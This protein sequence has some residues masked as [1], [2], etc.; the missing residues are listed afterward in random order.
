MFCCF[1]KLVFMC[2]L[3]SWLVPFT[4]YAVQVLPGIHALIHALLAIFARCREKCSL[5]VV[6]AILRSFHFKQ[7]LVFKTNTWGLSE[8]DIV[9][10]NDFA[11]FSIELY[12]FDEVI[13]LFELTKKKNSH[14]DII[15][16]FFIMVLMKIVLIMPEMLFFCCPIQKVG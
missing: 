5:Q 12:I 16:V 15:N 2:V 3:F 8:Q 7:A 10:H 11:S 1:K 6:I 9:F 4:T 13:I 14:D